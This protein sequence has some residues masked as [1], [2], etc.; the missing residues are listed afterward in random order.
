MV[1]AT[2]FIFPKPEVRRYEGVIVRLY[3]NQL[4]MKSP[5]TSFSRA[6]SSILF[7]IS[8]PAVQFIL[9]TVHFSHG[10]H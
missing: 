7:L 6:I 10:F 3:A 9:Q 4:R 8:N 5:G 2:D 1:L